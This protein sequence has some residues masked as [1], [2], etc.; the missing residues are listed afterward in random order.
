M[1]IVICWIDDDE[2]HKTDAEILEEKMLQSNKNGKVLFYHPEDFKRKFNSR[3]PR[4]D[5]FLVDYYLNRIAG[6]N[7]KQYHGKGLSF[8]G[9]LRETYP[10]LP[11]YAFTAIPDLVTTS[12]LTHLIEK[13]ADKKL[14]LNI[15]QES[16]HEFLYYDALD[17]RIIRKSI[18]KK[19]SK[20]VNLLDPPKI[21]REKITD[22]LPHI[23]KTSEINRE[24]VGGSLEYASWIKNI[25][26]V[27]PGFLYNDLY[28]SVALG[29]TRQAFIER[30][31]EFE[32]A[33]YKGLFAKTLKQSL[34]W[35]ANLFDIISEKAHE[36]SK[37][38]EQ[39][40]EYFS[41]DIKDLS[42]KIFKLQE[43]DISTCAVCNKKLPETVGLDVESDD[44]IPVHFRCSRENPEIQRILFFED[45][46]IAKVKR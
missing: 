20:L 12:R 37:T 25:F 18:K 28:S 1:K 14:D 27:R 15:I 24:L 17:Y 29:M 30:I 42:S 22:L 45:L 3:K 6:K 11:I 39:C 35:K 7:G 40:E 2:K 19:V 32:S 31:N 21:E 41:S 13:E 34:W 46:R 33:V 16:G 38:I 8:I 10:D 26:L 43:T 36:N 5:L 23:L 9:F 4:I 44:L